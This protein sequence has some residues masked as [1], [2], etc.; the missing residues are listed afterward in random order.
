M[1]TVYDESTLTTCG[2][3]ARIRAQ[4]GEGKGAPITYQRKIIRFIT[5][6]VVV[7]GERVKLEAVREGGKWVTSW[8]AWERFKARTTQLAGAESVTPPTPAKRA[9]AA[10]RAGAEYDR[11]MDSV[12]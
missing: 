12:R 2:L 6:G 5:R 11:L 10:Q 4:A 8:E 1:T 3:V 7:G 9:Q